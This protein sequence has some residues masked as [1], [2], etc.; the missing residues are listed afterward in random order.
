[1]SSTMGTP[2]APR[3]AAPGQEWSAE[4]DLVGHYLRE[5][6][7]TP[8]LTAEEEVDLARRIEAGVYAAEL[9]RRAEQGGAGPT[10]QP[11]PQRRRD[12]RAV[13]ADG[14]RAK[15]HM[16]RAN[17]RLVVSVAKKHSFR[18][19]P[20][21]D[22]VQEGNLGLIRAVEKFDYAKG[23]KF[24]TYAIWWIRQAIERGLADQIRTI[25]IPVHVTEELAKLQ[26]AERRLRQELDREPTHEEVA[27]AAKASVARVAELRTAAR[28]TVSLE[29]PV[30]DGGSSVAD[31]IE[32]ADAVQAHEAVEHQAITRALRALVDTLP[33]RQARIMTQ[34]YG[35]ADG[36]PRTLQE[37]AEEI[38]LTRERI[39]QLEKESLRLLRDPERNGALHA[40]T[41]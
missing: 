31:L 6:G 21:L 15:E 14:S 2:R 30:G 5:V 7:A 34:R 24:S 4:V 9:L 3:R 28:A 10:P 12:L 40:L 32:D 35:L 38:G 33:E 11:T 22:V 18:G 37:V 23:Y 27:R 26:K 25:R 39:R 20:L 41:A 19:L 29:T 13:A 17:L 36:R 16:I 8:L 1:M